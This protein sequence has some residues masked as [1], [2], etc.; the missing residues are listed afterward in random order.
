MSSR[1]RLISDFN[2]DLL[3]R[4]LSA[5]ESVLVEA[6]P[7]NQVFQELAG[8]RPD[9]TEAALVWTRAESVVP[10]FARAL[11]LEAVDVG[12]C[13]AEVDDLATALLRFAQ[14]RRHV[15]VVSWHLPPGHR[16]YGMLD[17][18]PNLGL[19]SLLA[20]MNLRLADRLAEARNV[21]LLD[22]SR[23]LHVTPKP[24]LPKLWYVAKIPYANEVFEAAARAVMAALRA[25][26]GR[27]RR[28]IVLDLDNTL[29]GGV[30]GEDGWRKIRL[31]GHDH[32]G[33]A[34]KDFQAALK[35]FA[36][37]GIQLGIVSKNDES[38]VLEALDCHPEM[39]L[40]RSDFAGWRI[41]WNDK[42]ENIL[43]LV[44]ELNLGLASVVF[45]DDNPVERDRVRH[46]L[47]EVLVPDW[48]DDPARFAGHLRGMDCFDTA[49]VSIEDR[50]RA[51]M[52]VAER[53]RQAHRKVLASTGEWLA[54][55][56]T[57]LKV[58]PVNA[59]NLSRVSQ[60]FN[61]TNQLNL[62]TRRLSE[63]EIARWAES[64]NRSLLAIRVADRFGDLGLV[65]IVSVEASAGEGRLVDFILSCRAMGRGIEQTMIG[66]AIGELKRFGVRNLTALYRQTERNRPTLDV[67][68]AGDLVEGEG[69]VFR[70]DSLDDFTMPPS[71]SI[72]FT[73]A[74]ATR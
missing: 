40:R 23:W 63:I 62:S 26:E 57:R 47:P 50:G 21:N 9:L 46:A 31:G 73:A 19:A 67:L 35:T 11:A 14:T 55:L 6:A 44:S 56:Q 32:V 2:A 48:P 3:A 51:A 61:K 64:T 15:F 12:Q 70:R 60:L 39:I 25:L 72:E 16:G 5:G 10:T 20:R 17:W 45:L 22:G 38:V 24:V 41:N 68:R 66:L 27:A 49:A 59:T 43:A 58:E 36:N 30:V 34:F 65:G 71:V 18:T 74:A 69:F 53:G 42:A 52:Y 37:R 1:L 29:W 7:F 54:T 28:L 8:A 4:Y 33:E 13:L